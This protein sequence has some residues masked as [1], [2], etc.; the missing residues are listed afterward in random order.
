MKK[1]IKEEPFLIAEISANHNGSLTHAKKLISMAKKYG[2]NAV[3]LQTYTPAMMTIKE[4]VANF[5]IK[6]GLWKGYTLWDLYNLGQTPL[7][8]HKSL[9]KYAKD[10]KI[11]IFSTPFSEEAVYFLEKLSCPA[12]KIASF[13]MNDCNLVKVAAKTKKPLILSTGLSNMKEIEKAVFVAK[14]NGCKDLTLLYCV[15]NYPSQSTDFNLNY[16]QEFKK[17]FNC[18][19]GL[20]DHSLG[21]EIAKYSLISGAT[22][23][24]KHI[25]LQNQKEGLDLDFSL[26]GKEL[27]V[28]NDALRQTFQLISDKSFTRSK[29]ELENKIFRRSIYAVKDIKK[30]DVLSK[31]NIRTFRP[32]KGISASYYLDIQNK[33]SPIDIKK[34]YP[35]P[36]RILN[37]LL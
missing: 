1:F 22:V 26:R 23:F 29:N 4:N 24:E 25:A 18:R 13:E 3:K 11:K 21:S 31:K 6:K 17:R 7:E 34:N 37:K 8:W 27:K 35:L 9:F 33:K 14:K 5:K 16:I 30:G 32:E 12:Y 36:K 15:S 19:V 28:Y 20:S 2:A 10:K